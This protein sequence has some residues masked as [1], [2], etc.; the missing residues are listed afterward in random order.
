M[1]MRRHL[2]LTVMALLT[3]SLVAACNL[4][5]DDVDRFPELNK[6]SFSLAVQSP[7]TL[8]SVGKRDYKLSGMEVKSR[9][10]NATLVDLPLKQ[11][12]TSIVVDDKKIGTI[13]YQYG[14]VNTIDIPDYCKITRLDYTSGR[15][16]AFKIE[17]YPNASSSPFYIVL[18][19]MDEAPLE[20]TI[21]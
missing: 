3:L 15:R 5:R 6:E 17:A 4:E 1:K 13:T 10:D 2:I 21:E 14:E 9:G 20:V 18:Y 12:N 16:C 7:D 8:Y 11:N 19:A